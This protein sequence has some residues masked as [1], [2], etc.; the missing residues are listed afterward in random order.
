M[1]EKKKVLVF[2]GGTEIAL[3]IWRS[4]KDCK[5][6]TL[7]SGGADISNHAPYVFKDYFIIPDVHT[8]DWVDVLSEL[9]GKHGIDYIFPAHDDVIIALTQNADRLNAG[10]ITSPL[11][12]CLVC[13]SKTETYKRFKD[14]LPVPKVFNESSDIDAFPVF[15]KPDKGQGS[16]GAY[17]VSDI[18]ELKLLI[19]DKK[20]LIMLEYLSGKEYT[21]DCFTDR[22]K[23]LLFCSGRERIR[24]RS[25]ISMDSKPVDEK[26]NEIFRQYADTIS[27]ELELHGAWFF[28]VKADNQGSLKLMEIAPRIG[29]TMATH[30][31]LG[32]NFPLLSI[33]EKEGVDIEIMLNSAEVEIDRA[34]VNRYKHNIQYNKV[35]VDFDDTLIIDDKVNTELIRFLYQAIDRGCKAILISRTVNDLEKTLDERKLKG[36]FDEIIL[37]KKEDS[38]ADF[39]DPEGAIFIDDSFSER[40]SVFERHGIPTFDC[41]MIELL[42]DERV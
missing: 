13:R 29:G 22:R 2:P 25:G 14:L 36:L 41:S 18:D 34:L 27:R 39:I 20:P 12:T 23:G 24:I 4:L 28:Q 30:R 10:I 7:Y 8:D 42:I 32:V 1:N 9:I 6:I 31:V 35:Y 5:E 15:V 19:R 33:Y 26:T 11:P 37:L 21:V 17:R 40:R 38:K 16:Q 3:E